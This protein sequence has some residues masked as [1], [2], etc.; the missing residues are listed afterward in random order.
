M[1][2][3]VRSDEDSFRGVKFEKGFNVVLG[4][5]TQQSV[6]NHSKNGTRTPSLVEILHF[7]LGADIPPESPLSAQEVEGWTFALDI[8][9]QG[10][11]YTVWRTTSNQ[12]S[13]KIEGDFS[14]WPILPVYSDEEGSYTVGTREWRLLL[15]Y[16]MFDLPVTATMDYSP[17]FSSLISYFIRCGIEAFQS[18][19]KHSRLQKAWD[20]QVNT[21][22]LLGLTWEYAAEFQTMKDKERILQNLKDAVDQRFLTGF[23]GSL[24]ELE[25]ERVR[26]EEK[27]NESEEQMRSFRVHPQYYSIVEEANRLTK[28]IHEITNS[29]TLNQQI[30][31]TYE[32][33]IAEEKDA[34]VNDVARLY[35]EAGLTFS[36]DMVKRLNEVVDF[37]KKILENRKDYL[38]SE[39]ANI[40][41][42]IEEEKLQIKSLSDRRSE[43]LT[44]L[45]TEGVLEEYSKLQDRVIT[46]KLQ[47][48][49]IERRI[50]NLKRLEEERRS[51]EI[52]KRSL[53]QKVRR[54]LT[55]RKAQRDNVI[56][57]FNTNVE[58]LYSE[59]GI[60]SVCSDE[61][62]YK[63]SADIKRARKPEIGY[64]NVFCYDLMLMQLRAQYQDMPGFLIHDTTIFDGIDGKQI[65]KVM[66]LAAEEAE[67]RNFQYICT[68]NSY[69]VPHGDF[70]DESTC[71]FDKVIS[72][73]HR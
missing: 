6:E 67:K 11:E 47:S 70:S 62:G 38:Q 30:L 27:I 45:K 20:I 35:A 32:E 66:E 52:E 12:S 4:Q 17:T 68:I 5:R 61:T 44:I 40:S 23:V 24:K 72:S 71:E 73:A 8:A 46:L 28:E 1:I 25:A 15:G 22:Y 16:V 19:F 2:K 60:F 63:F 31:S 54:D 26:L 56:Q 58:R 13:I 69:Y 53:L 65:A 48:G 42:E 3:A 7:C 37:H 18:P 57:L 9:L 64:M 51:L 55:E 59:P 36:D 41:R 33:S 39:I 29:Y 10:K 49:E 34:T 43:L 50:E 14:G 21:A